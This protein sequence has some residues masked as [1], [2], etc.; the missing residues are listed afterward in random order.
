MCHSN[1]KLADIES[2]KP[3][4]RFFNQG[5]FQGTESLVSKTLPEHRV[6]SQKRLSEVFRF[7]E[8]IRKTYV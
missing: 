2:F 3:K 5:P 8:D 6:N 4:N 7:R 1:F